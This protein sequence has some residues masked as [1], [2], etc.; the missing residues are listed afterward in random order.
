MARER[1]LLEKIEAVIIYGESGRNLHQAVRIFNERFPENPICRKYFRELVRK[2]TATGSVKR[3]SGSGKKAI[4]EIKQ[5]DIVSSVVNNPHSTT[6]SVANECNISTTTVK[7]YLKKHK[8][9]PYKIIILHE[10]FEDDADRRIEFCEIMCN[11]IRNHTNYV[12]NICFSDECSFSLCGSVNRQNVR[13]WSDTNPRMIREEHTQYPQRVNVWAGILGNHI[14]G[15]I[16]IDGN[17]TGQLYLNMLQNEITYLIDRVVEANPLYFD[18]PII[19]QQDGATPHYFR[20][21]REYL[22]EIYTDRWIGR[23]GSIEWPARSPDLT[24]MDFFLWGYLKSKVYETEPLTTD[25]LKNRIRNECAN[26][27]PQ[28]LRNVRSEFENRLFYC[29]EVMGEHFEHLLR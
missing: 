1:A 7:K 28:I 25:V 14:I 12:K 15:P 3:A 19:F 17:L 29:Q 21:V 8:F 24:P 6:K 4:S 9:H 22:N 5:I 16:F 13:Y 10:L 23:R 2:F 27:T 18:M 11:R 20:Q 26:I